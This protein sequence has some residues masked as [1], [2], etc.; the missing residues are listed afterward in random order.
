MYLEGEGFS[1]LYI[2]LCKNVLT[3]GKTVSPRLMPTQEI[4]GVTLKILNPRTRILNK[5]VRNISL[6]FAIGEWLWCM[7]GR[8]DLEMIK[9]YAPSYNKYSDDGL[10]LNGAYGPRINRNLNKIIKLLQEDNNTRRAVIPIYS[11]KDVGLNSNDI[12]CTLCLQFM[13]RD[14]KLDMYT[15][16]R[17]NDIYLGL[18]YDIFNFTMWQEYI[19]CLLNINIGTYTHIVNSMHFYEKDRAKIIK[20]AEAKNILEYAMPEMPRT[21]IEYQ[22]KRCIEIEEQLRKNLSYNYEKSDPFFQ[23]LIDELIKYNQKKYEQ[24]EIHK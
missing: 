4:S 10:I 9:Y 7:S 22:I 3:N 6:A 12:P 14:N 16:M 21:N 11:E 20:A 23:K 24:M 8:E 2:K 17:S 18:P 15:I 1:D 19:A 13:I 5:E